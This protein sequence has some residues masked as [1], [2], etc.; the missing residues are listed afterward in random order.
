MKTIFPDKTSA[1]DLH[2]YMLGAITPRPIA[3]VSTLDK[4]GNKNL[5]PFSYFNAISSTPPILVFSVNRNPDGSKKDTLLNIEETGECVINMVN[6]NIL[7]QMN[8]TSANFDSEISEF[9]KSG[10][11]PIDSLTIKSSRVQ[12]SPI[13]IECKLNRI[14][15]FGDHGGASSLI[16][17]NVNCLHLEDNVLIENRINP[18]KLDLIGRLGRSYY[19][20]TSKDNILTIP[21]VHSN[22]PIGYDNLPKSIKNS[23]FLS[24]N[25][26]AQIAGLNELPD[27]EKV[28]S[29]IIKL[30]IKSSELET[31]HTMASLEITDG[32]IEKAS[33]ILMIIEYWEE[34]IK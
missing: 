4:Q 13:Q 17:C 28:K 20:R 5:A 29:T 8:L 23:K 21:R 12:E 2:Q 19:L 33:E 34:L 27:I 9:E 30:G 14:I 10:L 7:N 24:G 16:I 1:R 18:S 31:I 15:Y 6:H 32:N 22:S 26:I 3:F 25:E 11:T